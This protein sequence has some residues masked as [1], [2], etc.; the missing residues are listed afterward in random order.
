MLQNYYEHNSLP[1]MHMLSEVE[2]GN[3]SEEAEASEEEY[4]VSKK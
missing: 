3:S 2:E 1:K 4:G